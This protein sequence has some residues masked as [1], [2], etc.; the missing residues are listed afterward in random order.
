M[1]TLRIIASSGEVVDPVTFI[2]P[3]C[4]S[5]VTIMPLV[6]KARPPIFAVMDAVVGV[7][8]GVLLVSL[9]LVHPVNAMTPV[10]IAIDVT[11]FFINVFFPK[12]LVSDV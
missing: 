8:V 12:I 10:S 9:F 7:V 4:T 5:A 6:E 1:S 3:A 2:A 11:S